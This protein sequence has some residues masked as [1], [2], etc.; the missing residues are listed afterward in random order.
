M[1]PLLLL[2]I[3]FTFSAC[4]AQKLEKVSLSA[5]DPN[6]LYV[7]DGDS[8]ALYYYQVKGV[9]LDGTKNP[10]SWSIAQADSV[11]NWLMSF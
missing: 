11:V 5:N 1:K 10:H 7:G 6:N 8:T 4:S 3:L 9:R 2:L